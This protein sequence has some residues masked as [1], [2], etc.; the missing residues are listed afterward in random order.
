MKKFT[1]L[2]AVLALFPTVSNSQAGYDIKINLK[3]CKDTT[4]YLVKYIFDQQY[5]ADTSLPVKNGNIVFK[6]KE[7]LDKG[8]YALVSQGMVKY[9]D[10]FIDDSQRFTITGDISDLANTL[11]SSSPENELMF[12]YAKF[13]SGKEAEYRKMVEQSRGKSKA[14][15]LAF[16]SQKQKA[17]NDEV[18]KF[19]EAFM[20]K[21]KG[22]FVVD[23]LNLRTEKFAKEVPKASN[24]RPDSLYQYYYYKSHYLDGINFK[25][26]RIIRVPF[27]A[28][29][30][31]KYI[32]EIIVQQPDTIIKELDRIF[33]KCN[34]G[35]LIYNSLLGHFTYKY[36]QNKVMSF[37]QNGKTTTFE[38]VFVHLADTYITNGKAKG[39]YDD[40]TA[41][42]IKERVDIIRNL[43]PESKVA[44]LFMIDTTYGRKVLKMGFDTAKS[45]K[46]ITDLYYKNV[47]KLTPLYKTL[48][49]V[50]A[51]YTVLVFWA[52]DCDHCK[53]EVPKLHENLK[54]LKGKVDVKVFAVQTKEELFDDWRKF[55][56]ENKLD[57]INVFDPVHL[58]NTK[59]R[60]DINSTP[61]IYLLDKDKKIKGKKLSADQTIEIIK[62]LESI[63]KS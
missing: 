34:Q 14:D 44:E 19:N 33:G 53:K 2:L 42:K 4:I 13:M 9:V 25:D 54:E 43:L 1:V 26:E 59:D 10:F 62:N 49:Q 56:I 32:N 11:R 48:Y 28:D 23:F 7:N 41:A 60:F 40:E 16:M 5:M 57:F 12:S 27:F 50:E 38:K 8:M 39:V 30:I 46:S 63:S 52:V 58:N 21:H 45:S 17:L 31:K 18:K 22:T 29:R 3:G 24:G 6:G 47:E 55:L 35:N 36:E 15:S 51:K 20:E 61:V 37:D